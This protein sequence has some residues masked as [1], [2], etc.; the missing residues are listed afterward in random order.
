ML[1]EA[2]ELLLRD[3]RRSAWHVN[4]HCYQLNSQHMTQLSSLSRTSLYGGNVVMEEETAANLTNFCSCTNAVIDDDFSRSNCQ[5][6]PVIEAALLAHRR[7][8]CCSSHAACHGP[9]S[10][11]VATMFNNKMA[12]LELK[13]PRATAAAS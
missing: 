4:P 2:S 3:A 6:P 10:P 5:P 12:E 1:L 9:A 11:L 7:H 8:N 13:I